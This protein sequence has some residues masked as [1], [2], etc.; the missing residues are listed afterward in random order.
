MAEG[1]RSMRPSPFH[2]LVLA[3]VKGF[4]PGTHFSAMSALLDCWPMLQVLQTTPGA[5]V[6]RTSRLESSLYS[7]GIWMIPGNE[8]IA[9]ID[10]C[11]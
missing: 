3:A 2:C 5:R 9:T 10:I 4:T 1:K 11:Y 6:S 7:L 8:Q